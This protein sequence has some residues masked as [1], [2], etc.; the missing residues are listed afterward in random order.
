MKELE[1]LKK[2]EED[3]SK[4]TTKTTQVTQNND[5]MTQL[6]VSAKSEATLI[7]NRQKMLKKEIYDIAE[8]I[9]KEY[10]LEAQFKQR[11]LSL[12]L[13]TLVK[14]L[15]TAVSYQQDELND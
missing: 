6:R 7:E 13:S 2:N 9:F 10:V 3:L 12:K 11:D 8:K 14:K 15:K 4:T 1:E 5:L